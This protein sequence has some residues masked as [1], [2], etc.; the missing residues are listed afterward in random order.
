MDVMTAV[1]A[2]HRVVTAYGGELA[3]QDVCCG[4]PLRDRPHPCHAFCHPDPHMTAPLPAGEQ[5]LDRLLGPA[6]HLPQ[7]DRRIDP[8]PQLLV[9]QQ[10][11]QPGRDHRGA[12]P[13]GPQR[14]RRRP[15]VV[16]MVRLEALD[17]HRQHRVGVPG[18]RPQRLGRLR[19]GGRPRAADQRPQLRDGLPGRGPERA[20]RPQRRRTQPL[21]PVVRRPAQHPQHLGG[22]LARPQP[23]QAGQQRARPVVGPLVQRHLREPAPQ[24][25]GE[26]LGRRPQVAHR[27]P[28]VV[29]HLRQLQRRRQRRQRPGVAEARQG[30]H[31]GAES[32]R[33]T[34]PGLH[35][36]PGAVGQPGGQGVRGGRGQAEQLLQHMGRGLGQPGLG[37][38]QLIADERHQLLVGAAPGPY[39]PAAHPHGVDALPAV[40]AAQLVGEQRRTVAHPVVEADVQGAQQVRG[41]GGAAPG[42]LLR[43]QRPQLPHERRR[44]DLLAPTGLRG[45][46]R[47]RVHRLR[48]RVHRLVPLRG[49]LLRRGTHLAQQPRDHRH[50][51]AGQPV[52]R[53]ARQL[54][55]GREPQP[56]GVRPGR[57]PA[58][59][60]RDPPRQRPVPQRD[61]PGRLHEGEPHLL[62]GLHREPLPQ[63]REHAH[64]VAVQRGERQRGR[65]PH[66]GVLVGDQ[67]E[68][69]PRARGDR[70][71]RHRVVRGALDLVLVDLRLVV[72]VEVEAAD[73]GE[74]FDHAAAV[75]HPRVD[76]QLEQERDARERARVHIALVVHRAVH[77][78]ERR[79]ALRRIVGREPPQKL[80]HIVGRPVGMLHRGPV[81][82]VDPREHAIPSP[83]S[84]Q[85]PDQ[86][87]PW[88][89]LS[90]T[91]LPA[92]PAESA[93]AECAPPV[94]QSTRHLWPFLRP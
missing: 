38:G 55:Q 52:G 76:G 90:V 26:R 21:A 48:V 2:V 79:L 25:P 43:G 10:P 54:G 80:R 64:G 50:H 11:A 44:R 6:G 66:A 71:R 32:G 58:Q 34:G 36:V 49:G 61:P 46:H 37:V 20:Q 67:L 5:R 42:V 39:Q 41:P 94:R 22:R 3:P 87:A 12:R 74:Q 33:T 28:H 4:R 86:R 88:R 81:D 77:A 78:V 68:E 8:Q 73:A 35:P 93:C 13:E 30:L 92:R 29:R 72:L 47:L 14:H 16:D 15:P 45:G 82:L 56:L 65:E 57:Q 1:P 23:G 75:L 18:D 27:E 51:I 63:Q 53:T 85:R 89:A 70:R 91:P 83:R 40:G 31:G 60:L 69:D 7:C 24:R 62:V 59:P 17:Q 84:R 19:R 9:R